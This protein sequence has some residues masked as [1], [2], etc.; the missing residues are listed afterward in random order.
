MKEQLEYHILSRIQIKKL[1]QIE[2]T[3]TVEYVYNMR[4]GNLVLEKEHWDVPDWSPSEQQERITD[5]RK[6]YDN[7]ATF[8]GA[9]DGSIL[10]GMSVLD[11][12][13]ISSGA[14][15]LNLTGLWVSS[16]YRRQA[17][18][19]KLTYMA[20]QEACTR[21]AKILYV[22]ATPSENTIRFYTSLGFQLANPVD[23]VLLK[24]EPDDIHLELV[25]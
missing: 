8:F 12:N 11:H 14:D 4:D 18:G 15:R 2:R 17:V 6:I 1:S 16:P 9:I 10:V 25:L 5:L 23:P 20:I 22:S 3:E 13:P 24:E 19:R 21:G 7:G